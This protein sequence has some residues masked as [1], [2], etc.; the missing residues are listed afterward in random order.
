MITYDDFAKV[1]RRIGE[2][3]VDGLTQRVAGFDGVKTRLAFIFCTGQDRH[4][5]HRRRDSAG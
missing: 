1:D 2:E 5:A 4:R 3:S